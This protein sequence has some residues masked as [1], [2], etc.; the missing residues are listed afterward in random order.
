MS[1]EHDQDIRRIFERVENSLNGA[2][3]SIRLDTYEPFSR[4]LPTAQER[5]ALRA[6]VRRMCSD[7]YCWEQVP[8]WA[9]QDDLA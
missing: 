5:N 1:H 9:K 2:A 4:V 7:P 3:L 6:S 8:G